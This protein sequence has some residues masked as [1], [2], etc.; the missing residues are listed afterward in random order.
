MKNTKIDI[1]VRTML[2]TISITTSL[3]AMFGLSGCG[4]P[5]RQGYSRGMAA[6]C[7]NGMIADDMAIPALPVD[8]DELWI[9]ARN[10]DVA[11]RKEAGEPTQGSLRAVIDE[12]Q[13][14]L[15]LAHTDVKARISGFVAGVDVTQ[16]YRRNPFD[17]K[18]EAV[19]IFP[20]PE[21]A[22]V[23]DFVMIVGERRIRGMVRER[24]EAEKIYAE[25]RA[26]GYRAAIMT[27]ER[28]NIFTQKVANIEPGKGIDVTLTYYH[29]LPYRDGEYEFVFPMVVGPRF[30]PPGTSEGIGAVARGASGQ[31]TEVAYLKPGE[32]SGH[33]IGISVELDAGVRI[34]KLHCRTHV[35]TG[36]ALDEQRMLVTLK[37]AA[38]IPNK[39]FVLRFRVAGD[40]L[41]TACMI[42]GGKDEEE[43]FALIL[44][45]PA[46]L[47]GLQ[48]M[49]RE[50]V[51]VLDC[52]GSMN[53]WPMNKAKQ[54][55]DRC[56][57]NLDA[58]DTFQIIRFSDNSSSFGETPVP[59][60][61]GNIAK[62]KR[63]V[64]KL[65]GSGGTYMI[66]GVK[67]ALDFPHTEGRLRIV[68]FMTDGY[69]GNEADILTAIHTKLGASRIFSF[70]VGSSVN[71]YLMERM[72]LIGR[73]AVAYVGLDESAA[74]K[75]DLFYKR[76]AVP[77]LA[78]IHIDW[79]GLDVVDVYPR[80]IPDVFVG[81]P[82]VVTGRCRGAMRG[83]IT[84]KGRAG[85]NELAIPLNLD[86][87]D[88]REHEG[89]AKIWARWRIK[90]LH[91]QQI[92]NPQPGLRKEILHTSLAHG[93]LSQYTAF[94]AVDSSRRTAGDHGV[95][96]SVPVPVPDGVRYDTTVMRLTNT[97]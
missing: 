45:P 76:I 55:M 44:Q 86:K 25:A 15:P 5:H 32:R 16:H 46:D 74:D 77:A 12:E 70:G 7:I 48:R 85:R 58:D 42:H 65:N 56:L 29:P 62:A 69:I 80:K 14:P 75:V 92:V 43:T 93:I 18:I 73:G 53:G 88:R 24:D 19:Y 2:T 38:A 36:K 37:H 30:N 28:P 79:G 33:D 11:P 1:I 94:L 96:V 13:V 40:Q 68:S 23:T 21:S 3:L 6:G 64:R 49:P 72:A 39:D 91:Q 89:I 59:A 54:A 34:E 27:Q 67:A 66:E 31:A 90:D 87:A 26:Q 4:Q 60:T 82:V 10:E 50:M 22:A 52:S 35:V 51:F 63:F 61:P 97:P 71:R 8:F 47:R 78:D 41:K 81:R 20:L 83:K 84:V 95:S 17:A 57:D 9:I